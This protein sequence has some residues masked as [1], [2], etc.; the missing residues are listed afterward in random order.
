MRL[1]RFLILGLLA[2]SCRP[3]YIPN[4]INAPLLTQKN[5]FQAG[6]SINTSGYDLQGAFALNEQI[7]L[8][9]NF[10]FQ[11]NRI[12][13]ENS[14][15]N[16]SG[17]GGIGYFKSLSNKGSAEVYAGFG[18]GYA[19]IR[20]IDSIGIFDLTRG[21]YSKFFLQTDFGFV[22]DA[23]DAGAA[24]RGLFMYYPD[25][26]FSARLSP[27]DSFSGRAFGAY[28]EPAFFLKLGYKNI[29]FTGQAGLS[30]PV[31]GNPHQL[32]LNHFWCMLGVGIQLHIKEF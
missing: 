5:E 22:S 17:E 26:M 6:G 20:H 23:F 24:L 29:K 1:Y 27:L 19:K 3:L 8:I 7:G 12:T 11:N 14:R 25:Y 21:H 4:Y 9:G 16:Y 32:I 18:Q 2:V 13:A 15:Y 31:A 30:I 28:I 10:N